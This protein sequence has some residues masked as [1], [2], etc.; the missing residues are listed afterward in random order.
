MKKRRG[1]SQSDWL[2]IFAA[3]V[4]I[5]GLVRIPAERD[6]SMLVKVALIAIG[7]MALGLAAWRVI[8]HSVKKNRDSDGS[9]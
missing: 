1:I 8:R 2:K 9:N 3:I 7:C 4:V 5:T 6:T